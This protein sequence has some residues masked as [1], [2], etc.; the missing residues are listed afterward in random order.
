M[1]NLTRPDRT[2]VWV[3][4][5]SQE[6]I[7]APDP[8]GIADLFLKRLELFVNRRPDIVCLPETFACTNLSGP[9]PA[10]GEIAETPPGPLSG[11]F[12]EFARR[13]GCY[14]VCP[15]YTVE[16]GVYYNAAVVFDRQGE[17]MGEYRSASD[18]RRDRR[19]PDAGPGAGTGI[20][21]RLR[22][23]RHPDLF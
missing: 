8:A 4:A 20:R 12:A 6:G 3:A 13:Q 14:L 19:R 22:P 7:Y 17:V 21:H 1:E 9:V 23:D 5:L 11:R 16:H 10:P 15:T 2:A 18:C